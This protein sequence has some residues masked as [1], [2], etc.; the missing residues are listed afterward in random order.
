MSGKIWR[1]CCKFPRS[2]FAMSFSCIKWVFYTLVRTLYVCALYIDIVQYA[3]T[4]HFMCWFWPHYSCLELECVGQKTAEN[5]DGHKRPASLST[6]IS[7][8]SLLYFTS[9]AR[10]FVRSFHSFNGCSIHILL[11]AISMPSVHTSVKYVNLDLTTQKRQT[12]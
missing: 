4:I 6:I 2:P 11:I 5:S 8:L 3:N 7:L 1:Y 9:F 12:L 10:S